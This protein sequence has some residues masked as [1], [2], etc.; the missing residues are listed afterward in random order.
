MH[1]DWRYDRYRRRFRQHEAISGMWGGAAILVVGV[2]LL[3]DRLGIIPARDIF[4]FWPMVLVAGGLTVL[5][6]GNGLTSH[7]MGALL[8]GGGMLLQAR[9]LGFL[10]LRG[11]VFWPFALIAFGVLMLGRAIEARS[12]PPGAA[13]ASSTDARPPEMESV[14]PGQADEQLPFE[15]TR[16]RSSVV[17]SSMERRITSPDFENA[18]VDVVF[19]E[20]VLDLRQAGISGPEARVRADAVFGSIEILLPDSWEVVLRGDGVFGAV[21]D[22]TRHPAPGTASKRLIVRAGAVFGGVRI[23]N[24]PHR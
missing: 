15:G 2:V 21:N 13:G 16:F 24:I 18:R 7:L 5:I 4:Q 19:G 12:A 17:F 1:R 8:V 3:L 20:F 14:R 10:P 23:A 11:D 9:N 6:R 22:E